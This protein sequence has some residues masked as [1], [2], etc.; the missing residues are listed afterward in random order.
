MNTSRRVLFVHV[1]D[2]VARRSVA[3]Q[4]PQL[5]SDLLSPLSRRS[6]ILYY[7]ADSTEATGPED[8]DSVSVQ[9]APFATNPAPFVANKE[10]TLSGE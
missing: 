3:K 8:F 5:Q 9:K 4:R 7:L 10:P 1:F 2:P 6:Y